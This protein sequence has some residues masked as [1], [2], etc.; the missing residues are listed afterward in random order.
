MPKTLCEVWY[1]FRPAIGQTA[2]PWSA[3]VADVGLAALS[4]NNTSAT[5][6]IICFHALR[7][8]ATTAVFPAVSHSPPK[9]T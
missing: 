4:H 5:R 7:K 6:S 2:P 9:Q 3:D 8:T 1:W